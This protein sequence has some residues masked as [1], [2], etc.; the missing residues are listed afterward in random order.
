MVFCLHR[1]AG[2]PDRANSEHRDR[3][4]YDWVPRFGRRACTLFCV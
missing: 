1:H 2:P 4:V 3:S